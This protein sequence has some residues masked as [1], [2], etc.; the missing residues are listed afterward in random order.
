MLIFL[1]LLPQSRMLLLLLTR[2][3]FILHSVVAASNPHVLVP[4]FNL[5]THQL[6]PLQILLPIGM[7]LLKEVLLG[8]RS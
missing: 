8:S 2:H 5:S 1:R 4:T 6:I 3:I 7:L